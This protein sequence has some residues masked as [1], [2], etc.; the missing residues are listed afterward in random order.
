[1][2]PIP[3]LSSVKFVANTLCTASKMRKVQN[4]RREPMIMLELDYQALL[5]ALTFENA[6]IAVPIG[7]SD[8][9]GNVTVS[10]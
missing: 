2:H 10:L 1:M 8:T 5:R 3:P 9:I 7:Y 4:D 6:L